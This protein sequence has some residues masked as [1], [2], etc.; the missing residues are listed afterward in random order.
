M[1]L[2]KSKHIK[3]LTLDHLIGFCCHRPDGFIWGTYN[4]LAALVYWSG[5]Q[6]GWV[7]EHLSVEP[8]GFESSRDI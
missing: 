2:E 3:Y 4:D 1:N 8:K 5:H 7:R 6:K